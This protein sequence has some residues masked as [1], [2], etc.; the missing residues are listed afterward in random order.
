MAEVSNLTSTQVPVVTIDRICTS[1]DLDVDLIK[2]DTET[3][4]PAVLRGA[5]HVLAR[6]RPD[7]ICEVLAGRDAGRALEAVLGPLKYD[8]FLLTP[9][10]PRRK[11]HIEGH[12]SGLTTYFAARGRADRPR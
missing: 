12:R 4:E 8:Y 5:A 7:I 6:Q 9:E 3:T 11:A 2:I 1:R 10:G